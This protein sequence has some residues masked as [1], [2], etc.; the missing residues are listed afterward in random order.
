[1]QS[2]NRR[3][4][5]LAPLFDLTVFSALS[6]RFKL[7]NGKNTPKL[8]KIAVDFVKIRY[9]RAELRICQLYAICT[10]YR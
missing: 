4:F 8:T 2:G 7:K 6:R 3:G 10:L 9:N 5:V 1:M